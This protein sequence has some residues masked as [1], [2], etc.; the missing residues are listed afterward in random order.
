MKRFNPD[1]QYDKL[2][3]KPT[4]AAS[5]PPKEY[6]GYSD[7]NKRLKIKRKYTTSETSDPVTEASTGVAAGVTDDVKLSSL[8]TGS[9]ETE[10]ITNDNDKDKTLTKANSTENG[11]GDLK[12]SDDNITDNGQNE[13]SNITSTESKSTKDTTESRGSLS[14]LSIK[15]APSSCFTASLAALS[16]SNEKDTET[17]TDE[18]KEGSI[19]TEK[20]KSS[21]SSLLL[22]AKGLSGPFGQS[23][24]ESKPVTITSEVSS[25]TTD[26]TQQHDDNEDG[27]TL[28]WLDRAVRLYVL[29]G[30][31]FH[32]RGA[33]ILKVMRKH[34][35]GINDR[36][37]CF[38]KRGTNQL[39]LTTRLYDNFLI[40]EEEKDMSEGMKGV[41]FS[42]VV[43][44]SDGTS[45][46]SQM[47]LKFKVDEN[48][49]GFLRH[50]KE[51]KSSSD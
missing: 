5:E 13:H 21:G 38:R 34:E 4:S 10:A 41:L 42:S 43:S 46:N 19:T 36:V 32:S 50:V 9:K 3:P 44:N 2:N 35:G 11:A 48:R 22:S 27:F 28:I 23:Q 47:I 6:L 29:E 51:S 15:D 25:N 17:A 26:V 45:G 39:L 20:H 49:M 1:W 30:G 40:G 16:K 12:P 18:N 33:G 37:C 14:E 8:P 7:P 24:E 31:T